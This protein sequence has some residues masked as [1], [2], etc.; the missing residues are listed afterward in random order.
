MKVLGIG[1]DGRGH[2][3]ARMLAQSP[4]VTQIIW[5]PGN[6][7]IG[8]EVV[9]KS[10]LPVWCFNVGVED[11]DG[12]LA[13]AEYERPDVT[14]VS[15]E[16]SII[17]GIAD[18]FEARG[19]RIWA[20]NQKAA[21]LEGS[22]AFAQKFMER[23][24]IACPKGN[25]FTNPFI[26]F[27]YA[28]ALNWNCA[29][30]ADGPCYGKGV[31][32]CRDE[33]KA[34]WAICEALIKRKF[35]K[36]GDTIVIQELLEGNELSL[37]FLCDGK[38]TLCLQSSV[39]YKKESD[40]K[41]AR[42]T[43]SMGAYS[44]DPSL[45]DEELASI[46]SGIINPWTKGC[47]S[48]GINFKGILFPGVMRTAEGPKVLEF[49]VRGGSPEMETHLVR[50]E[51]DL[52]EIILA[53]L[54]QRLDRLSLVWKPVVSVCVVMASPGYPG[55]YEPGKLITGLS[56]VEK[57]P[58][59]KVFHMGTKRG[60]DGRVYTDGGRVLGV[61]A[62]ADTLQNARVRAYDAVREITFEGG[63]YFRKDIG[64]PPLW[65]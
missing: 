22:K 47:E 15:P 43:G 21:R 52:M 46:A 65:D 10:G 55:A 31:T 5:T 33:I 6:A 7:G 44:P 62:W 35:G 4:L 28:D 37:H 64:G 23:Y 57:M 16:N 49:G 42:N 18:R 56:I 61:T 39:D 58:N 3:Y 17:A 2:A 50:L 51:T 25:F 12:L 29:V 63:Q 59:V 41:D 54:E 45:S 19:F 32:V 11:I 60:D 36:A 8:S 9:Q 14:V 40:H 48:E 27:G 24:G 38:T 1:A 26:A 13:L 30:K 34:R 53:T 20:P